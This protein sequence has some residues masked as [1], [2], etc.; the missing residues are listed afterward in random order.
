M[1]NSAWLQLKGQTETLPRPSGSSCSGNIPEGRAWF[2]AQSSISAAARNSAGER[3]APNRRPHRE[4][5]LDLGHGRRDHRIVDGKEP[6]GRHPGQARVDGQIQRFGIR[7]R[8]RGT[9]GPPSY[10][11]R[12]S[13]ASRL[14]VT[15]RALA[16][17]RRARWLARSP[18]YEPVM[19]S[20]MEAGS[21][22]AT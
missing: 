9:G 19:T 8:S 1:T 3:D 6:E 4:A 20:L 12:K 5:S 15:S 11:G 17:V 18:R 21:S 7:I 22:R 16:E 2:A 13:S 10:T 14:N